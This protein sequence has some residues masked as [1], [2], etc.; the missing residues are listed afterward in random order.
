MFCQRAVPSPSL[1]AAR[2]KGVPW[3]SE[4]GIMKVNSYCLGHFNKQ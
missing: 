2:R 3:D 4:A 1:T